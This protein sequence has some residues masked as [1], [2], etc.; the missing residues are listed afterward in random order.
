MRWRLQGLCVCLLPLIWQHSCTVKPVKLACIWNRQA[1]RDYW[2]HD[3]YHITWLHDHKVKRIQDSVTMSLDWLKNGRQWSPFSIVSSM[4]RLK[5]TTS[6]LVDLA[7]MTLWLNWG[8]MLLI[9]PRSGLQLWQRTYSHNTFI[10]LELER[11]LW[12][13]VSTKV[14]KGKEHLNEHLCPLEPAE[15]SKHDSKRMGCLFDLLYYCR[16][17]SENNPNEGP[18]YPSRQQKAEPYICSSWRGTVWFLWNVYCKVC[19]E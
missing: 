4:I 10:I 14:V 17:Q 3:Y 15:D 16:L 11:L 9:L 8:S 2:L 1:V 7:T 6:T 12:T 13:W 18:V 19:Q 5:K